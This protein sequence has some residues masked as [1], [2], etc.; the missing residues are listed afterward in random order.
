MCDTKGCDPY[1]QDLSRPAVQLLGSSILFNASAGLLL[2]VPG[3]P[4]YTGAPAGL[5]FD[6]CA[7]QPLPF[8]D[9]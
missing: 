2:D 6:F 3:D 5:S 1:A 9:S 4:P 8:S 7:D